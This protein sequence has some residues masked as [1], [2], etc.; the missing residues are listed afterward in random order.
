MHDSQISPDDI[1]AYVD[2]DSRRVLIYLPES[3]ILTISPLVS[4]KHGSTD[5]WYDIETAC[6]QI[7]QLLEQAESPTTYPGAEQLL[8]GS[9]P[10]GQEQ[11]LI[12]G[13]I[14]EEYGTDFRANEAGD[15]LDE[16]WSQNGWTGE[17][18]R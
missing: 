16:I 10:V 12:F 15:E 3:A 5:G 17:C 1:A 11:E 4:F 2:P 7:K 18:L 9:Y 14:L 13:R 8:S 6:K